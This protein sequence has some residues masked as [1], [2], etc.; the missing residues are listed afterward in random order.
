MLKLILRLKDSVME[1]FTLEKDL[2][3][4]GRSQENDIVIDNIAI[5]RRHAQIELKEE[6]G[7]VVRDLQSSNGTSLNGIK[8]EGRDYALKEGDILGLAKFELVVKQLA[9]ATTTPSKA[10][11]PQDVEGTMIIDAAKRK[12]A[13]EAPGAQPARAFQ[14]PVLT[15]RGGPQ[16]GRAVKISKDITTI[17][18]GPH[19]DITVGGWFVSA[20]QAKITRHGDRFYISHVGSYFSSTK[21]NGITI[22]EDHILKNKDEIQIGDTTFVFTQFSKNTSP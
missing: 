2:I 10:P 4:I 18:S 17:G 16:E 9:Y 20:P 19:D 22:K 15:A 11:S 14:W 7:Y 3:S 12:P 1:E 6:A 8:I 5:S 21:V 13:A